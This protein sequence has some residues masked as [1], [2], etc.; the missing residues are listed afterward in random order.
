MCISLYKLLCASGNDA[1][2]DKCGE[3]CNGAD[4]GQWIW[5]AMF[6]QRWWCNKCACLPLK[7]PALS[8]VNPPSSTLID[9]KKDG[10]F[11]EIKTIDV[12]ELRAK[13]AALRREIKTMDDKKDD[14]DTLEGVGDSL[15]ID[16]ELGPPS[17]V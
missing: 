5:T 8:F 10:G 7:Y 11:D 12:E 9:V 14:N 6:N 13:R 17:F 15:P 1:L 3:R 2:C 4:A 16:P